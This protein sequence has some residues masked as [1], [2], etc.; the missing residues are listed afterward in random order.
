MRNYGKESIIIGCNFGPSPASID[1]DVPAHAFDTLHI[2]PGT[3]MMTELVT[4]H[5]RKS[6]FTDHDKLHLDI[7]PYGTVLWKFKA[8]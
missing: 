7:E 6:L 1:I 3:Y 4:R 8:N 5:K 2:K